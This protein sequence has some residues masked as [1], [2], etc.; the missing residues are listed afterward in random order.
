M[1]AEEVTVAE[2]LKAAGYITAMSG[3]WGLG[4]P[5]TSGEPNDQGFDHWFGY[6]NQRRAHTHYP[7]YLWKNRDKVDLPL[8]IEGKAVGYSHDLFTHDALAF[9][10]ERVRED[11]SKPF[12][13]YLPYIVPHAK[14]EIPDLGIYADKPWEENEK[15]HAAM[16]TRLDRDIGR[17]VDLLDGL[18]IRENTIVFICSDNGAARRWDGR[19]DASGELTGK[20]RSMYDGGIRTPMIV[21]WPGRVPAGKVSGAPW[22]F[23]DVLPALAELAG[24]SAQVPEQVDG[25]SVTSTLR[26][27]AQPELSERTMYWEFYEGGFKQAARWKDWKAVRLALDEDA[28]EL[29]DLSKDIGE[30]DNLAMAHPDVVEHFKKAFKEMRTPSKYFPSP[31]D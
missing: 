13:L 21:S 18:E 30:T 31:L 9:I 22:Y 11:K 29:Y 2:V 7:D 4:E 15:V 1:P 5:N 17:I 19:F 3:N 28:I 12:F 14:Y 24:V 27:K 23:A 10:Q 25:I 20:K 26:G 6:L 16:I 8:E